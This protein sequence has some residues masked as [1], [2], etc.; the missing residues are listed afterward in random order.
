VL[1]GAQGFGVVVPLVAGG[2]DDF[3]VFDTG[4]VAGADQSCVAQF[5]VDLVGAQVSSRR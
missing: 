4:V 5:V 2:G 3:E 1:A